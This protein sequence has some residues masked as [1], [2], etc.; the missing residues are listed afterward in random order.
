M[1]Q[2]MDRKGNVSVNGLYGG[3]TDTS[4][5]L[6]A[7][8][9]VALLS[10]PPCTVPSPKLQHTVLATSDVRQHVFRMHKPSHTLFKNLYIQDR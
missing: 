5:E 6:R 1:T 3:R 2:H 7:W 8:P 10:L 4:R 9:Q